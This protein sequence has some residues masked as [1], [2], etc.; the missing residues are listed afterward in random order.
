MSRGAIRFSW[1]L[2]IVSMLLEKSFGSSHCMDSQPHEGQF[3][4]RSCG[5]K[6][7]LAIPPI[8][9]EERITTHRFQDPTTK[10][11]AYEAPDC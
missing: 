3:K 4:P 2:V 8:R 10:G 1:V 6:R 5:E 11:S 9:I 7:R